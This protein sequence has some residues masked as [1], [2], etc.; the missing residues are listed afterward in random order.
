MNATPCREN[1]TAIVD[2][3]PEPTEREKF[4]AWY[5]L[6]AFDLEANPIGSRECHLQW[7]AWQA[8][9]ERDS[10]SIETM[11][12]RFLG[13]KLPENFHPDNGI[14]FKATFNDH[15]PRPMRHEPTG[16]NLLDATQ[17]KAMVEWMLAGAAPSEAEGML[18]ELEAMKE[19]WRDELSEDLIKEVRM[20][21]NVD[22]CADE[23]EA[24]ISRVRADNTGN[25]GESYE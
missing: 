23:L 20:R 13:W 8:R 21:R 6:N 17:A 18:R 15:L 5:T 12:N 19:Q 14:S 10:V 7:L 11:V 16:T 1:P 25:A 9:S 2:F 3:G 22:D 4:E 24:F